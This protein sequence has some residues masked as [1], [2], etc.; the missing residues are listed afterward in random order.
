M[1]DEG[2]LKLG[3]WGVKVSLSLLSQT[4]HLLERKFSLATSLQLTTISIYIK[5]LWK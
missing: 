3:G 2:S 5:L 4:P 1:S